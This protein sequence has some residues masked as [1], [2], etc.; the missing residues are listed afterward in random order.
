[1]SH[2]LGAQFTSSHTTDR[3]D[4]TATTDNINNLVTLAGR[5]TT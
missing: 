2:T 3:Q 5:I 1:M 4:V